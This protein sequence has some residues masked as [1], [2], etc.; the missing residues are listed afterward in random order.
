MN[1][2]L[3]GWSVDDV[4]SLRPDWSDDRADEFLRKYQRQIVDLMVERGWDAIETF[5]AE[6]E[7]S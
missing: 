6:E 1:Y 2:A 5:L 4:L 7:H 3:V